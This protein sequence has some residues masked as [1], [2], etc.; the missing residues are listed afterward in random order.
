MKYEINS[1]LVTFLLKNQEKEFECRIEGGIEG[2]KQVQ[3][4]SFESPAPMPPSRLTPAAATPSERRSSHAIVRYNVLRYLV[5]REK[6][7]R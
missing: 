7:V 2:G 5:V 1:I 4:F 6:D 3:F